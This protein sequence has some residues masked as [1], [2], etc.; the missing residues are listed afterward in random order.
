[1]SRQW[2]TLQQA[3]FEEIEFG[4]RNIIVRA[5]AGSGKTT[6]SVEGYARARK[7]G[8]RIF[9]AF[10]K[11][12]AQE[13]KARGVNGRTFHSACFGPVMT[14]YGVKDVDFKKDIRV[15][16]EVTRNRK[17]AYQKL[18]TKLVG[19]GKQVGIGIEG[20]EKDVPESWMKIIQH[21]DLE[22]D[23]GC[24]IEEACE[25]ASEVLQGHVDD[26]TVNFDDMLYMAVR[27]G[28]ALPRYDFVFVD[29]AQD[30]NAI[31]RELLRKM[32][33]QD[34]RIV[35]VGDPAQAIYGF[36][37]ADSE[38]MN[39]IAQ[40]FNAVEMPL[41]VTYR[42]PTSVVKY[43]QQW[44]EDIHAREG[45]DEGVVK[46]LG[47]DWELTTFKPGDLVVCRTTRHL[48]A[49][50]FK[51]IREQI[52]AHIMGKEIGEGLRALV[53]KLQPLDL[54]DLQRK[55]MIWRDR[56]AEKAV[57]DDELAKADAIY[58]KADAIISIV[59]GMPE[60]MRT[61]DHLYSVIDYLF[62]P[63]A[64]AIT[65]AT[66]HKSK[67][68]EADR[69]FWLNRSACPANWARQPWQKTQEI[70]LCYV[71]ATRAKHEL[72]FLEERREA[73]DNVHGI[74]AIRKEGSDADQKKQ[75]DRMVKKV[76]G[77]FAPV[78][79]VPGDDFSYEA[80]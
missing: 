22:I 67:G 57:R 50:G 53:K 9:L 58:D 14:E 25:L 49:L 64:N 61:V 65:L 34:S 2:S 40:E 6:T 80:D 33:K 21:H 31:Q 8:Q 73:R 68:L 13:L 37:G 35:A 41:N 69:V 62:A 44:V 23:D 75:V 19:L 70:N 77:A 71:A 56:E 11:P 43:A 38:S 59:D 30:T 39:M 29:E 27:K 45:A 1:M 79:P 24:Y 51:L 28:I 52:P 16:K 78:L 72:Y 3:I 42:C 10:N 63:N 7:H 18:V 20:M 4:T 48:V 32:M 36:R 5:V 55:T 46:N 76:T 15:F 66:I 54:D 60:D 26:W 74:E 12:I 17:Y 47:K